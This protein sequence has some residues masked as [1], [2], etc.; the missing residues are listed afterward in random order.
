MFH[1]TRNETIICGWKA[2]QKKSRGGKKKIKSILK[3]STTAKTFDDDNVKKKK[4]LQYLLNVKSLS[5][6][7]KKN[8]KLFSRG[9]IK[10]PCAWFIGHDLR[11]GNSIK[12]GEK[13][14]YN[15]CKINFMQ[16]ERRKL[17]I[18]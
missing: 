15:Y 11:D 14:K 1:E 4:Y 8:I 13:K 5:K 12:D 10:S 2:L 18:L 9:E 7:K 6:N 16:D 17:Y 3:H